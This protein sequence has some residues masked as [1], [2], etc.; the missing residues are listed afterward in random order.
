M[1]A[2]LNPLLMY[3]LLCT[4]CHTPY[5]LHDWNSDNCLSLSVRSNVQP[6]TITWTQRRLHDWYV[7]HCCAGVSSGFNSL[8]LQCVSDGGTRQEGQVE[9]RIITGPISSPSHSRTSRLNKEN[10]PPALLLWN[11]KW[12]ADQCSDRLFGV[13][14]CHLSPHG[15]E[16]TLCSWKWY[17]GAP[18]DDINF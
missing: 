18:A 11:E 6:G 7:G 16:W 12:A 1:K 8:Y 2:V 4:A 10:S 3:R 14:T 9:E 17:V 15:Q 13:F 5:W